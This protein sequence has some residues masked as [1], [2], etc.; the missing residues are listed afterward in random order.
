MRKLPEVEVHE[1]PGFKLIITSRGVVHAWVLG[2]L[3]TLCGRKLSDN[4][5]LLVY[6][7]TQTAKKSCEACEKR[8]G[9]IR[10]LIQ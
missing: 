10:H 2:E 7:G 4:M 6:D 5:E 1:T 9:K 8:F 3:K